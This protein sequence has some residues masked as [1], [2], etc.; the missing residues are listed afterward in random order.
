MCDSISP[1]ISVIMSVYNC[2]KYLAQSIESI[3]NQTFT[4]FEFIIVN[5]GSVDNTLSI[6]KH[7]AQR[8]TRI[9]FISQKNRGLPFAL[10]QGIAASKGKYTARMDADDISLPRRLQVQHELLESNPEV[11]VCGGS[12]YL[13]NKVPNKKNLMSHP[14]KHKDL[15]VKLLFSVCFIHPTVMIRSDILKSLPYIYNV[16]FKNSQ[17]YELWSRLVEITNFFNLKEPL[18]HYRRDSDSITSKTANSG[19][20]NRFPLVKKTQEKQ[21]SKIGLVTN[22][23]ESVLHYQLALNSEIKNINVDGGDVY[24]HLKRILNANRSVCHFDQKSLLSFLARKY[25]IFL[26]LSFRWNKN[27]RV[28][29]FFKFMFFWG[30]FQVCKDKIA[31]LLSSR[32]L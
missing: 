8:D 11:G 18:I 22:H 24:R 13:F 1:S 4:D 6:I 12:A 16:E 26:L 10:N 28:F 23:E 19:M 20:S 32:T 27:I 29:D 9:T 5:D 14:Q 15:K 30:G 25:F 7:Y 3:L 31:I 2:E 17:D 21:L